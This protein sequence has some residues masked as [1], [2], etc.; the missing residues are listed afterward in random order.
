MHDFAL[1]SRHI[2]SFFAE[3]GNYIFR[4]NNSGKF[5]ETSPFLQ[6]K[7]KAIQEKD[8]MSSFTAGL[9]STLNSLMCFNA[10]LG[11]A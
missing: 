2:F 3:L 9:R 10:A 7:S 8:G 4:L 1:F 5:R 6:L 11:A